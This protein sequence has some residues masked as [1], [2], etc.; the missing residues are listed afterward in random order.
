LGKYYIAVEN[1]PAEATEYLR[2][3][4]ELFSEISDKVGVSKCYMQLGLTSYMLE[5][6]GYAVVNFER[7]LEFDDNDFSTY[8]MARSHT[9]LDSLGQA[10]KYF[11]K[12]IKT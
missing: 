5:Y 10:K 2:N 6:Y 9:E 8:L 12:A 4:L 7:S 3:G 1:K 11:S